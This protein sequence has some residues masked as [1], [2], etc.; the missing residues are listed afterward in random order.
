MNPV[1]GSLSETWPC[2]IH[3]GHLPLAVPVFCRARG[4]AQ[5]VRVRDGRALGKEEQGTEKGPEL[6]TK[7][8]T[9]AMGCPFLS[10]LRNLTQILM[11]LQGVSRATPISQPCGSTT[12]GGCCTSS[13]LGSAL[14]IY[15]HSYPTIP[16]PTLTSSS[17]NCYVSRH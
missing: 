2:G 6:G 8:P 1:K 17:D 9:V 15:S 7:A 16:D 3:Q 14:H 12:D 4:L 10:S 5:M 11:L 13:A